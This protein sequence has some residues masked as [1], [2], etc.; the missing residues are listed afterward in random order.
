MV[1]LHTTYVT[2]QGHP[3]DGESTDASLTDLRRSSSLESFGV[4]SLGGSR[5]IVAGLASGSILG[6]SVIGVVGVELTT[7]FSSLT[8]GSVEGTG[9]G[10]GAGAACSGAGSRASACR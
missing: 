4:F 9:A 1:V 8:M 7:G 6:F 2:V 5:A 3:E 10:I